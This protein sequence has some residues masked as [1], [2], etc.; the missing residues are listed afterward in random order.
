MTVRVI[1]ISIHKMAML[2]QTHLVNLV[3]GADFTIRQRSAIALGPELPRGPQNAPL[4][5]LKIFFFFYFVQNI[6]F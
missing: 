2:Y 4:T 1:T 3:T 6:Y 5:C